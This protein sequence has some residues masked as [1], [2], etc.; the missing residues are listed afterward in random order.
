VYAAFPISGTAAVIIAH[1][2]LGKA[3]RIIS[4]KKAHRRE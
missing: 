2:P 4:I 3:R 1:A